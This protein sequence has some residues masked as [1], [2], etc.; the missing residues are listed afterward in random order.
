MNIETKSGAYTY[1][2]YYYSS[3][4]PVAELVNALDLGSRAWGFDSPSGYTLPTR[5]AEL[6]DALDLKSSL[7]VPVQVR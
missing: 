1:L 3:P 2:L 6:V 4:A 7:R 5:L